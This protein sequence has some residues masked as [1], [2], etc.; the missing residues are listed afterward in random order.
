MRGGTAG[1]REASVT[2]PAVLFVRALRTI[3]ESALRDAGSR[4]V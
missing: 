4:F 2:E 1:S 3:H